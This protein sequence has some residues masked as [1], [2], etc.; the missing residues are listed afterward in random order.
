MVRLAMPCTKTDRYKSHVPPTIPYSAPW[1]LHS[2]TANTFSD[3]HSLTMVPLS[4]FSM[5]TAIFLLTLLSQTFGLDH[6]RR[7]ITFFGVVLVS[8]DPM[9]YLDQGLDNG[10]FTGTSDFNSAGQF[11]L[12]DCDSNNVCGALCIVSDCFVL[13]HRGWYSF[14]RFNS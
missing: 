12:T 7:Q 13:S 5:G 10:L 14:A 6:G 3:P 11:Q 9:L 4:Y 1:V 8:T 2:F